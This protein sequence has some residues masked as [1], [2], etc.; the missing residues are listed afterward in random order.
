M[1]E[2]EEEEE[3]DIISWYF[4]KTIVDGVML[5]LLPHTLKTSI[6][7]GLGL[8]LLYIINNTACLSL[9][10]LRLVR[11]KVMCSHGN[12]RQDLDFLLIDVIFG[13]AGLVIVLLLAMLSEDAA[14][15]I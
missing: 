12:P 8:R 4:L 9:P 7:T 10:Q 14:V 11:L 3:E 2:E 1:C 15:H 13:K 6:N 5:P